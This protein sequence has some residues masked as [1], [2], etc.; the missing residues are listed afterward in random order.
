MRTPWKLIWAHQNGARLMRRL[1]VGA[2]THT[3]PGHAVDPI[4]RPAMTGED[5]PAGDPNLTL[6][7]LDIPAQFRHTNSAVSIKT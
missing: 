1:P 7:C 6:F 3:D 2:E 4:K 5:L